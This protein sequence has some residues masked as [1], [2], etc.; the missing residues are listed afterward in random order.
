MGGSLTN[1][2]KIM[3]DFSLKE[4]CQLLSRDRQN[5]AIE[6]RVVCFQG[7]KGEGLDQPTLIVG[8]TL[9]FYHV[10]YCHSNTRRPHPLN[11]D[12]WKKA[13]EFLG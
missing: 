5:T 6:P 1:D 9:H 8:H 3:L 10:V 11:S 12:E 13:L 2:S 4:L 7:V